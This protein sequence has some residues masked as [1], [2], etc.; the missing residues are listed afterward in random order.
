L[1]YFMAIW[2]FL[3]HL[4]GI[5]SLRFGIFYQE[6]SGTPGLARPS[7]PVTWSQSQTAVAF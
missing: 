3:C 2:Q 6:K 5:F 4:V 7:K 1:V